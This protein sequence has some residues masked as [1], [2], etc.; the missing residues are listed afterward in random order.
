MIAHYVYSMRAH[1]STCVP[2][3]L[4]CSPKQQSE[5]AT[6]QPALRKADSVKPPVGSFADGET[7][8]LTCLHGTRAAL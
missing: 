1:V 5:Q 8:P 3:I 7:A 2:D 4:G 6:K